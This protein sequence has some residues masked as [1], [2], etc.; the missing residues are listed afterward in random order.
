[1]TFIL[2]VFGLEIFGVVR[3]GHWGWSPGNGGPTST[4]ATIGITGAAA[5]V[6]G[7]FRV[8]NDPPGKVNPPV[9]VPGWLG[10]LIELSFYGG[11][12]TGLG[13][14][15]RRATSETL[16]TFVA[17][18]YLVMWDRQQWL[19]RQPSLCG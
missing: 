10:V 9:R 18:V 8:R 17:I 4:L 14:S 7:V 1:M 16:M 5:T 3:F 15:G 6:R 19:F 13:S 11:A 12:T 2:A